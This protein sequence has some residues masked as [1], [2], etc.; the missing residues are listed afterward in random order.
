MAILIVPA[1]YICSLSFS[2]VFI[3]YNK[4]ILLQ[5]MILKLQYSKLNTT[6]KDLILFCKIVS[7][8]VVPTISRKKLKQISVER[9]LVL[10]KK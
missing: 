9:H 10:S 7:N 5:T 3:Y 1:R 8:C 2:A 4:I 6:L